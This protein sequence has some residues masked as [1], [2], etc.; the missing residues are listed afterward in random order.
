MS[1]RETGECQG[2]LADPIHLGILKDDK[3]RAIAVRH[4]Y[5]GNGTRRASCRAIRGCAG[6]PTAHRDETAGRG[7]AG[8][9]RGA[10]KRANS[11]AAFRRRRV[12]HLR[13]AET[14]EIAR[15]ARASRSGFDASGSCFW[16]PRPADPHLP[17]RV[18]L[19]RGPHFSCRPAALEAAPD[20][21][22]RIASRKN[23]RPRRLPH[24]DDKYH[25][26][27]TK[28]PRND[29]FGPS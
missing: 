6:R 18:V 8:R 25:K 27:K 16:F 11:R 29:S 19:R 20:R 28:Q 24:R 2:P 13:G 5:R 4:R 21:A 1:H 10:D 22:D 3:P 23:P 9:Q 12:S 17:P 14:S 15:D 7:V 26:E